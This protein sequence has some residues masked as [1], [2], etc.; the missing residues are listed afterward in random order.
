MVDDIC[1]VSIWLELAK[2]KIVKTRVVLKIWTRDSCLV[3][4]FFS[5]RS[6][7]CLKQLFPITGVIDL[8]FK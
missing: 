4:Y 2:I 3:N 8:F 5:Y 6:W 7:D 1:Y